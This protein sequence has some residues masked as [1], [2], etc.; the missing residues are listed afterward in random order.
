MLTIHLLR[1]GDTAQ[2]AEGIF[3]GDLDPSLTDHG[4][5]QAERV[6]RAA[7][8]LGLGGAFYAAPSSARGRPPRRSPGDGH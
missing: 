3:C 5:A 8:S 2:A 7:G 1:H 4:H 6:A